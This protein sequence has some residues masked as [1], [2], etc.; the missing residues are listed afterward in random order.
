MNKDD[1]KAISASIPKQPG[2]Y[3]FLDKE[4]KIIYVGKAKSLK[5]RLSSYFNSSNRPGKSRI[6]V[7]HAVE[8]EYTVVETEHDALLLEATFAEIKQLNNN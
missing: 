1:F 4:K 3:R 6:M 2:V 7:D 8:L 5:N